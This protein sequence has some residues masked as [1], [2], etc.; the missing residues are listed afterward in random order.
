MTDSVD[1]LNELL[2]RYLTMEQKQRAIGWGQDDGST[3]WL[4]TAQLADRIRAL[5]LA[6]QSMGIGRGDRVALLSENR[7]EWVVADFAILAAGAVNVPI[8]PGLSA[9]QIAYILKDSGARLALVSNPE[10]LQ[11]LMKARRQAGDVENVICFDDPEA[12]DASIMPLRHALE[13]GRA[14][15]ETHPGLYR[16]TRDGVEPGDLASLIYTSGTTGNPKGVM[17]T[18]HNLASNVTACS[19]IFNFRSDDIALSFLPPVPCVRAHRGLLL[20]L[21]RG[22]GDPRGPDLAAL[23]AA[24]GRYRPTV[25]AAVPRVY[26]K[27]YARILENVP[28][29]RRGIFDWASRLALK[30]VHHRRNGRGPGL[31]LGLQHRVA[32]RLVYSKIRARMG[33]RVRF[34]NSGGAPLSGD[35][36]A[37]LL[38]ADIN[39]LEG[40]GL[41]ETSPVIA[42]NVMADP[43]P[44]TV[45]RP[46][47]GVEVSIAGDGEILTRGPHVMRGYWNAPDATRDTIDSDGW[48]HT[49]D[50]GRL[51]D[52]GFVSVTDRKK[53]ILVTAQGKNVAP[54][55]LENALKRMPFIA[56]IV[57]IG[58]NRPYLVALVVPDFAVLERISGKLGVEDLALREQ[59]DHPAVVRMVQDE[60]AQATEPFAHHEQIRR[61]HL[62]EREFTT[63]EDEFDSHPEAQA[64]DHSPALR[65]RNPG[66]LQRPPGAGSDRLMNSSSPVRLD[67]RE[68][69]IAVV[70]FHLAD[71]SVNKI[72]LDV[73]AA[74]AAVLDE[75]QADPPR[76]AVFASGRDHFCVGAD[77]HL[78]AAIDDEDAARDASR[79]GQDLFARL[80]TM[81]FPTV[82]GG[83][84]Q[85]S[86]RRL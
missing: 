80:S 33:G 2:H 60:I 5:S 7:W 70:V 11:T 8:H 12:A 24:F 77:V 3:A 37:F 53:E 19:S 34:C 64:A 9:P 14:W 6:L 82:A 20:L 25:F 69:G 47:P 86:G 10:R 84:R 35:L 56:Q 31:L 78:I 76:G 43:R 49:G 51:D 40:Y 13:I 4:T 18:H 48:L 17:L 45:G 36:A 32:D 71:E 54:Q 41:T 55:P 59:L 74:L 26:E 62:L 50:I 73:T 57:I 75:L 22:H 38:G 16:G 85:L 58:D 63:E 42:T 15:G 68:D 61:F 79:R 65:G 21:R 52:D 1:T 83:A 66:A 29:S 81:G 27:L 46:V 44:G 72:T 28:P 39:V 23:G 30:I 67:R